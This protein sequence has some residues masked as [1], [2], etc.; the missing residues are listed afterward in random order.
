[1]K[2]PFS[3]LFRARDKPQDSVSAAPV[4][5]FGTSGSGKSVTV[6]SAIQLSTVYACVRVISET[7]ASLPLGIYET[8][9]D[10]NEKATDHPL[11][12]LLHDEPNSEMTSFVFREVMLAHLLLYG[13]SYSQIIRSGKN[14]VIGLY[15]LLP[16]H[17][18]VDRD[19]KGNL[20]YTYTTSDGKTV[21]MKP[22]DVLH[23]PGLGFDGVMGYS[24]IAL[25]KNAIGLGIA[26][27]EYGSKFFSNG[28]RPSGILTH[29]N[30]VKNPK[31]LRESWNSAYGGS[32]NSNRVAILEE[33]M[34]FEPIAIPNNEAQFLETR[35]FQV[36]EICRIFRVPPHLVGNLEHA[37]FSNIEH[38]SIDFAVHTIRPWLVRI[39]QAMNRALLSDQEKG[40]FFVQ[41]N[42]DGLMRGDYKSRME[43]YAIGRQNGWL[44][45]NDIRALENQNPIPA[46]Q[47][48]DAY[49][50]NGNMI[51]ISTAMKQQTEETKTDKRRNT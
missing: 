7:I 26:S 1:M 28:A 41:F 40:R 44:S 2:N 18:D 36:D 22:R 47:G 29:P 14:Q 50:V 31:A 34:K 24:P 3:G 5:Y 27:E 46:D 21:V 39:E 6:Q 25:E 17:M 9:N 4:F 30:T 43:G 48:G 37:T 10:G 15:P 45:A 38:Q 11:Y 33:G 20:T 32:S 12:R 42:I 16:D 51:S 23:I 49:L 35:K 8:V 13:N 19:S